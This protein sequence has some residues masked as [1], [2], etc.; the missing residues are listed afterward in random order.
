MFLGWWATVPWECNIFMIQ[1]GR[2]PSEPRGWE[3]DPVAQVTQ[4]CLEIHIQLCLG[5]LKR[6]ILST[7]V[8]GDK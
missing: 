5:T 4:L 3:G 1:E 7:C 6:V 8:Q 2:S